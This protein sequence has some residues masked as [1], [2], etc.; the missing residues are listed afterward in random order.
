MSKEGPFIGF[1][2][3]REAMY[4]RIN[5]FAKTLPDGYKGSRS[6]SDR[7]MWQKTPLACFIELRETPTPNGLVPL[8]AKVRGVRAA[9]SMTSH[10]V[11][12]SELF[13]DEAGFQFVIS[14]KKHIRD[15]EN[16][17]ETF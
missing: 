17:P 2:S 11:V 1:C 6:I 9:V 10:V 4:K 13:P 16:W 8:I 5:E 12:F 14:D 3:R 15:K 7:F